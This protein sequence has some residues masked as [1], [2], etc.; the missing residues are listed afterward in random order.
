MRKKRKTTAAPAA[1][2]PLVLAPSK[3]TA[4]LGRIERG[5]TTVTV[6]AKTLG[7][8]SYGVLK[9]AL[10]KAG[11]VG[12]YAEALEG[13]RK[14]RCYPRRGGRRKTRRTKVVADGEKKGAAKK[15]MVKVEVDGVGEEEADEDVEDVT[16]LMGRHNND[17]NNDGE[18]QEFVG[19]RGVVV[20]DDD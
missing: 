1:P 10:V 20:G 16:Q 14:V 6:E 18:E 13:G 19:L 8:E 9:K 17:N 3:A 15:G 11:G 12:A 5:E 4:M 2:A 7:L